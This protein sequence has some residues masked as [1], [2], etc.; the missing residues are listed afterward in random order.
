MVKYQDS[1]HS[2]S[3][4]VTVSEASAYTQLFALW[5]LTELNFLPL[6]ACKIQNPFTKDTRF[7][8]TLIF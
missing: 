5:F 8:L 3:L 4:L 1:T 7:L 2:K 6:I